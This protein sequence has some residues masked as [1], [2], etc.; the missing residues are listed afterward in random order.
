MEDK[1]KFG[2]LKKNIEQMKRELPILLANQAQNYFVGAFGK[3]GFDKKQ[4]KD[5]KRH[6]TSTPEY[7]YPIALRARKLSS[8]ILVG[9]Y[10]GRS[11]GTLRR[12]VSNSIQRAT[13]TSVLLK[14]D[15]PYA[16]AQNEGSGDIPA[17]PFMAKSAELTKMHQQKIKNYMGKLWDK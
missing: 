11:G 5:V 9:V 16:A 12:A 2:Q 8:P 3:H 7:K 13:F 14:V 6:D 15:L 1:F 10:K 4:W 17:R